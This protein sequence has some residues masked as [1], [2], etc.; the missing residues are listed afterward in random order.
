VLTANLGRG[1]FG[2]SVQNVAP[3]ASTANAQ[4]LMNFQVGINTSA[5]ETITVAIDSVSTKALAIDAE[6]IN[7]STLEDASK[8][9]TA[10][11]LATDSVSL[12]R[13]R[14]GSMQN[15]LQYAGDNVSMQSEN[16]EAARSS[17]MD[18]DVAA[19]MSRLVSSQVLRDLGVSMIAQANR[20][21]QSLMKLFE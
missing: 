2:V 11:R 16:E 14:L 19:E 4:F 3:P 6:T 10:L 8:A 21:P 7:I 5:A 13:A 18:L 1:P 15:R 12:F 17:I 9:G 20:M